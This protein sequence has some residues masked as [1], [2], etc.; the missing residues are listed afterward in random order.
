MLYLRFESEPVQQY[1]RTVVDVLAAAALPDIGTGLRMT[2]CCGHSQMPADLVFTQQ[3]AL[4]FDCATLLRS[5][6]T[7]YQKPAAVQSIARAVA[8]DIE[9]PRG[10]LQIGSGPDVGVPLNAI[11]IRKSK[12]REL[13]PW[14]TSHEGP[15]SLQ[16][17]I[18]RLTIAAVE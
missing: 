5:A 4:Y 1:Q 16:I 3:F 7:Q 8:P 6:W 18:A 2:Y 11:D 9:L 15:V 13:T 17:A 10:Q 12:R 14:V